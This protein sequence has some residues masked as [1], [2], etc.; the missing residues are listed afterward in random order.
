MHMHKHTQKTDCNTHAPTSPLSLIHPLMHTNSHTASGL[1]S[2]SPIR[3]W[4]RSQGSNE[5]LTSLITSGKWT[6]FY[7]YVSICCYS[8]FNF[9]L[10]VTYGLEAVSSLFHLL[11]DANVTETIVHLYCYSNTV[12]SSVY[13]SQFYQTW[14]LEPV[15]EG[16]TRPNNPS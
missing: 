16:L 9:D 4:H 15:M 13:L 7:V 1:Y 12:L 6:A 3:P 8:L 11:Y 2:S 14:Q 10:R 5:T